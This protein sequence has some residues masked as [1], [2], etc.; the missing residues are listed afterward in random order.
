MPLSLLFCAN[1]IILLC[2][3]NLA[4]LRFFDMGQ[5]NSSLIVATI[6]R[7]KLQQQHLFLNFSKIAIFQLFEKATVKRSLQFLM[8]EL[9]INNRA[10]AMLI[11]SLKLLS[12]FFGK[13]HCPNSYFFP[14]A[15]FINSWICLFETV[16]FQLRFKAA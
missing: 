13:L 15:H 14:V 1:R 16:L 6:C 7:E 4:N 9:S 11:K 10:F 5:L 2:S 8:Q 3:R 12:Y